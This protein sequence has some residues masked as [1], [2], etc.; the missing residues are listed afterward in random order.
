MLKYCKLHDLRHFMLFKRNRIDGLLYLWGDYLNRVVKGLGY[1]I[2]DH[3][4]PPV[5]QQPGP[6][7][8]YYYPNKQAVRVSNAYYLLDDS[9]KPVMIAKYGAQLDE[10]Q[11]IKH[12]KCSARTFYR[13]LSEVRQFMRQELR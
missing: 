12:C 13:R 9:L 8:P 5:S 11:A 1:R 3:A 2:V 4:R 7:V 10:K 6:I